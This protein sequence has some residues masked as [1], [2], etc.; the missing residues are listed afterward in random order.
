MAQATT[1]SGEALVGVLWPA[2]E[3]QGNA[4]LRAVVLAILGSALIA[5][6]AK[7]SV[8]FWPVPLTMQTF[9]VLGVGLTF[10]MRQGAATLALYLIEGL[11]GLPVFASST[12]G[13]AA[14]SGPT[15]GYLVGFVFAA[16][17][18]GRLAE[19]GWDRSPS[20]TVAAMVIGNLAIYLCGAA[21][22]TLYIASARGLDLGRAFASALSGGVYPFLLGDALKILL[23]TALLWGAW[24]MV[25]ARGVK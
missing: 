12:V 13:P 14:F 20:R 25:G 3:G 23:A 24:R 6:S 9:A 7:I 16:G 11:S 21:W 4:A 22:L 8:P 5:L 17:I 18:V 2:G 10:G 15:G 19:D 1:H